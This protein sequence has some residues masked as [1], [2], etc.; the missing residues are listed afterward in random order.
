MMKTNG[1]GVG[2]SAVTQLAVARCGICFF[3][4]NVEVEGGDKMQVLNIGPEFKEEGVQGQPGWHRLFGGERGRGG[5]CLK[6]CF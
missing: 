1:E 5:N 2:L 3:A 6:H 4:D